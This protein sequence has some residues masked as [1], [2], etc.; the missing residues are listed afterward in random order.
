VD[1]GILWFLSGP[2]FLVLSFLHRVIGNWGWAIVIVTL[3]IKLLFYPLSEKS[4]KSM[5]SMRRL[6][7]KLTALKERYGDN[8][9]EL[10]KAT[11]ELY[12][13]EKVNPIGS[14][15][16]MVIQI[17]VF[18]ALYWVLIE[19]VELR[20][21]PWILWIHDL[22]VADPYYVMPILMGITMFI[23]QK[24]SPPPPDPT[25][26]K[27]MMLMPLFFTFLFARFAAGLVLYWLAN[28]TLSIIQQW[29]VMRKHGD[30]TQKKKPLTVVKQGK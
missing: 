8:K 28:N 16:P 5:A 19:S 2:I 12:R 6:T 20:Q 26:A 22:S 21:A 30:G 3:L 27:L 1:Y 11:M 9:Q 10:T 29:H 17:P 7:P 24:L 14:C 18:I 25:Q 13:K 15:L 23:Q 4:Y